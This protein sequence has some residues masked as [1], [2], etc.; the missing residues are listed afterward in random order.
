MLIVADERIAGV[1]GTFEFLGTVRSR[2]GRRIHRRDLLDADALIVRSLTRVDAD[3]LE[4]TSVRFVGTATSGT[5][6]VDRAYLARRGIEFADAAG[7]NASAVAEYVVAALLEISGRRAFNLGGKTLGIVGVGRIGSRVRRFA[8]ALGLD[9]LVCDPPLQRR[10][11][12]GFVSFDELAGR[13]D[14]VTL[15]VPLTVEGHDATVGMVDDRWLARVRPGTVFVNTSRGEVVDEPALA[16]AIDDGRIRGAVLDVWCNEP[17][18]DPVLVDRVEI[19]TPHIAGYSVES[20]QRA[21]SMMRESLAEWSGA[22]PPAS[23]AGST[24]GDAG[25]AEIVVESTGRLEKD[26]HKVVSAACDLA[27]VDR[28]FRAGVADRFDAGAY[29]AL[30]AACLARRE[31][32][33]YRVRCG[34]CDPGVRNVL[35][36]LGFRL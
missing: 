21:A 32:S 14:I 28:S 31:F 30:R 35:S 29:D 15:H 33:R 27:I 5:D 18:V 13:S 22:R 26:A 6:H 34:G 12:R 16:G 9:A 20:A 4:G 3:L 8:E 10:G 2:P 36:E 1:P 7:C 17:R 23:D 24:P 19:A 25:I 11:D